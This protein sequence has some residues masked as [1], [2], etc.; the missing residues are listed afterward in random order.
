LKS[1]WTALC[2]AAALNVVLCLIV[3]LRVRR[4]K[5]QL[6]AQA[7]A[8]RVRLL[9]PA[10]VYALGCGF[11]SVFPMIDVPRL[12]LHGTWISRIVVGRSVA[13]VAELSL[14]LEL[15]L[16]LRAASTASGGG[17]AA[18]VSLCVV[19]LIAVAEVFS[20]MAVLHRNFL[21][22]AFE[23]SF[24]TLTAVLLIVAVI[25]LRRQAHDQRKRWL[26]ASLACAAGYVF[27]MVLVDVPMYV[28]RWRAQLSAGQATL[29]LKAG[30]QEILQRCTVVRDLT[31]WRD[32]IPWLTLY[33]TVAVWISL[34]LAYAAP[35]FV[36]AHIRRPHVSLRP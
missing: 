30:F 18:L 13:T 15:A 27:Y 20:W 7:H 35:L 5:H 33:F 28:S 16:M 8:L 19:P 29:S 23:N 1:W 6:S 17:T 24:W 14:A 31:A 22:H 3:A 10:V 4:Q 9:W 32:D 26:D 36:S 34:A 21:L 11:R 25:P 2:I 12:C